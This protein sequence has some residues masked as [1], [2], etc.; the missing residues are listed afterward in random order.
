MTYTYPQSD[1]DRSRA[2][3]SVLG[4]F[5][6]RTY[7]ARDQVRSY[8]LATAENVAQSY[9]NLLETAA[10]L[11][12]YEVPLFHIENWTPIVL[13]KSEMNTGEVGVGRFDEGLLTFNDGSAQFDQPIAR[14]YFAFPRPAKLAGVVQI[15]NKLVFPTVALGEKADYVIDIN[16]N[17]LVF[18]ENPFENPALIRRPIYDGNQLV[19]EEIVAWGFRGAFDYEY[20]FRQFAYALGMRL[21]TSQ[22]YKD[23]MNAVTTGLINGGASAAALDL[24]F[25]AITGVS[26]AY[27][28]ETVEVIELDRH[29]LVIATSKT[30]YRFTA[31]AAPVVAVGDVLTA[32]D[33]LVDAINIVELSSGTAPDYI[34]A[35]ALDTGFLASCFYGD[36]VFENRAVPLEVDT[37]HPSGYTYVKFELGG[38]PA[39]VTRFFDEVHARGVMRASQPPESCPPGHHRHT[40][41]HV[42][43]Q[44]ARPEYVVAPQSDPVDEPT[45]SNL[46]A[47]INP[48]Q[49]VTSNILRNNVFLVQIKSAA[50]GQNRL[51]LYNIRH[52]RQLLPPHAAMIVIYD[53][54]GLRDGI[55]GPDS[56]TETTTTFVG[57]QPIADSVPVTRVTDNGAT[58]R[59]FSGT[60]Q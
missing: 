18:A 19:D 41:A 2:L 26:V 52:L 1:L 17:A 34:S 55:S 22:G 47:V 44:R 3:L 10:A 5:W 29:G 6:N 35:L 42:L 57:M 48:L 40:L 39:D 54:T 58:A 20:V 23:L 24:A 7:T 27:G 8:A 45:S 56:L 14:P 28:D 33:R 21:E 31:A 11:S 50:L 36:L 32:G 15:F 53:M 46:P 43:D 4:S 13:K 9:R 30:V 37:E 16:R 59:V 25:S 60:C 51:G 38:F 12:R 49:F